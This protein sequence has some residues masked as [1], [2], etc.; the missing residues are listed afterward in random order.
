MSPVDDLIQPDASVH[1]DQI[2]PPAALSADAIAAAMR[3]AAAKA[4]PGP[5]MVGY[6]HYDIVCTN[7]RIGGEAKL[8][9]VR[10]WGYLTGTGHGGL[11]LTRHE[12]SE[13]QK[14]NATLAA[15][16]NPRDIGVLLDDRD[17]LLVLVQDMRRALMPFAADADEW[18]D[19]VP[20]DHRSLCTEPGSTTAHPGS[21]TTY[22]VGDLRQA[23]MI[24]AKAVAASSATIEPMSP[25]PAS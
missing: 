8:F 22:S 10:G 24:L 15:L 12:A 23:R 16:A 19:A 14:A 2:A 25:P 9:D 3:A 6:H 21:E 5:W 20:D 17:R 18:A 13:I 1:G 4:T 11:G 7:V